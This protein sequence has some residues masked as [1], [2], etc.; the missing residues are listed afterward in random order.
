[1]K[2]ELFDRTKKQKIIDLLDE[3]YGITKL[4]Y[5]LIKTGKEKIR[6]FSGN[7]S[8]D[9]LNN[10]GK[11]VHVELIGIRLCSVID[12]SIRIN[13]DVENLPIIK[14]QMTKNIVEIDDEQIVEWLNGK[15][16]E[17]SSD[18]KAQFVL[19]RNKE[20]FFGVASNR[21]TFLQNYVP[22]ERRITS[23]G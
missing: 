6:C 21:K 8:W 10:F 17:I 23:R 22:K 19:I 15:S 1:M 3:N 9:E 5:L 7:L 12:E 16:L 13:F 14:E 11:I 18:L 2:V 20:D 4:P